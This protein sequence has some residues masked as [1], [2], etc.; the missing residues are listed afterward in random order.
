[1]NACTFFFLGTF[2]CF[3]EIFFHVLRVVYL[4]KISIEPTCRRVFKPPAFAPVAEIAPRT[5][6]I[7]F[8]DTP[9]TPSL[10]LLLLKQ[11]IF[12]LTIIIPI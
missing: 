9:R 12:D 2:F 5:P 11:R 10:F 3:I 6:T 7:I 1:M 8:P 4:P